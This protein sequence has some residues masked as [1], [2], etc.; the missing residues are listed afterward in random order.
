MEKLIHRLSRG[1]TV[2]LK[3][4]DIPN[5]DLDISK[6]KGHTQAKLAKAF[7]SGKGLRLNLDDEEIHGTGIFG[8]KFD[9]ALKKAGIRK[10]VYKTADAL[11]P[12]FN[13]LADKGIEALASNPSTALL[14]P[15]AMIG[16]SYINNPNEFQGNG[17]RSRMNKGL[18]K[19]GIKKLVHRVGRDLKPV[20]Q[21]F[22][23]QQASRIDNEHLKPFT[24]VLARSATDAMDNPS[25]Y[26]LG[27]AG[28][29]FVGKGFARTTGGAVSHNYLQMS[30]PLR[31]DLFRPLP[32]QRPMGATSN[33]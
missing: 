30:D 16:K 1:K 4:A 6:L 11:K 3:H 32:P 17:V 25:D 14:A 18:K 2:Q 20:A 26:G 21:D 13:E 29:G 5:L 12:A 27:F 31:P 33:K 24:D 8:R 15:V 10:A 23:L 9:K 28:K 19:L 7:H 22:I